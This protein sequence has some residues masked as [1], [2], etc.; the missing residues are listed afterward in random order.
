[1]F[2]VTTIAHK[3]S[4]SK[5]PLIMLTNREGNRYFFGKISEG[6][7]RILNEN[8]FKLGKLRSIFLT[9]TLSSWSEIGGLPGLFLT[10]SDATKNSIDIYTNSIKAALYVVST[11][12]YFVFRKGVE[13]Q[14][15]NVEEDSFIADS[16]LL[17]RPVKIP[18]SVALIPIDE[19]KS[20]KIL[21]RLRKL[22]SLMFPLD[23]SKVNNP[24]PK[25][26]RSDP[27]ETEIQTHVKLPK[28][29][30]LEPVSNQL[31]LNYIIRFMPMRGKFDPQKA[32]SL[33]IKPGL[34]FRS[35]T[36]GHSV[37]NDKDEIIQPHQVMAESR[38]FSKLLI[39]DIP[40]ESYLHNTINSN[41]WFSKSQDFG[42]EEIGLVYHFLG[43]DIDFYLDE[44][45]K[46]L[47]RFPLKCKHVISH[48]KIADDTLVFKTSALNVLKLKCLQNENYNLPHM[49]N[50]SPLNE[51][52]SHFKLQLLQKFSIESLNVHCDESLIA[53]DTWS[54]LF[55]ENIVPLE[56]PNVDK[57]SVLNSKPISLEFNGS[58]M[59]DEIQIITLGTGSALPSIHR[60]VISTLVRIPFNKDGKIVFR[61]IMLDGGEN[62]FG[63]MLRNFGHDDKR[64]LHQVFEEL[65]L[66]HLSHLHA[67][68]HLGLISVINKWFEVNK[69]SNKK[70]YLIIPWQYNEFVNEWYNLEEQ[71]KSIID[72]SRI[73]YISCEDFCKERQAQFKQM[74][75]SEFEDNFDH[76]R[77]QIIPRDKIYSQNNDAINDLYQSL[78]INSIETVRAIH[79]YWSYSISIDFTL[80]EHDSFKVSY[81]G[82]TRP[83]PKFAEIGYGSDLLI[84]ES[85][86]DNDLIEEAIS[87][88]HSTMIE[89]LYMA[90]LMNCRKI[91]LTHF[92]TRYSNQA[93]MMIDRGELESISES[94][95]NYLQ[96][97]GSTP[98][99]FQYDMKKQK[100]GL[101]DLEISMAFDMMNVKFNDFDAQS[102]KRKALVDIFQN[103]DDLDGESAKKEKELQKQREK[104][105]TKRA[106]RLKNT[107]K[108]KRRV[109]S[110]EEVDDK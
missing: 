65:C 51:S 42:E 72:L 95:S 92:S 77:S 60:N 79:C 15:K 9:G 59:K 106:Q 81:S 99:I 6:S 44:Y 1:M 29:E 94:L 75:L 96:K 32:K 93:N 54:T 53:N 86:L 31:S 108:K 22:V 39:I 80:D 82:D 107:Q 56:I 84:H 11:W 47:K 21:T 45:L 110:D 58:L 100:L 105:E 16:N 38:N 23:T 30:E 76:H 69:A 85:S 102:K 50:Y 78:G 66:I 67:D 109:S 49:E 64:Q 5:H 4:D 20:S 83:N 28:T 26:Y 37:K 41:K 98:N 73:V 97:Y 13:L 61:S 74:D 52:E 35:L 27:S 104:K 71:E 101:E 36:Q 88:K 57:G 17:I 87:K 8:R 63:T 2:T 46:F 90:S 24:D 19:K 70:L 68:H 7:Q 34:D 10:I 25:S 33:G 40:N 89:A 18:S 55:D 14:L 3:T 62:T 43:D 91:M 12:R 103:E 48:S